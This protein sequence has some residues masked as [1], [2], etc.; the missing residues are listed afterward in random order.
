MYM[1]QDIGNYWIEFMYI[2]HSDKTLEA[3]IHCE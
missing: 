2:R 3:N 1:R